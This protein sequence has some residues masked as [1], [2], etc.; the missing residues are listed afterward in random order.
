MA[1]VAMECPAGH[2]DDPVRDAKLELFKAINDA[3]P[4]RYVRGQ[5]AGYR[6]IKGVA[7]DSTTET[8][9]SLELGID[10]WRWAGVPFFIRAGKEMPV[11]ET[12]IRLV[13]NAAPNLGPAA[14]SSGDANHLIIRIDPEPG[15]RLRFFAKAA[16]EDEPEPADFDVLFEKLPGEDPEPY[17]RLLSDAIA[18]RPALFARE[19]T[20]EETWRIVQPLLDK[21]PKVQSYRRGTWGPKAANKLTRGVCAWHDPWMPED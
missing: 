3:D 17:E 12:E 21:P 5:Y 4:K 7:N 9:A 1:L 18:G 6:K 11:K 14:P 16:G 10:N 15:A 8:F 19:D 20:I 13:F 2:G